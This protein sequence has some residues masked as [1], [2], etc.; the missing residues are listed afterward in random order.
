LPFEASFTHIETMSASGGPIAKAFR[1]Q[2]ELRVFFLQGRR[3]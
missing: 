2:V 3:K 1:D